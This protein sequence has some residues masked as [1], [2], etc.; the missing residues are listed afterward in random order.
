[1][2]NVPTRPQARVAVADAIVLLISDE[3]SV[4]RIADAAIQALLAA[5][6]TQPE[7]DLRQ[8]VKDP[9]PARYVRLCGPWRRDDG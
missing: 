7:Y 2:S 3:A 1:M 5:E 6:E 9:E 4:E 8:T